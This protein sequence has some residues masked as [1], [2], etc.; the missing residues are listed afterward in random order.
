SRPRAERLTS[1][2][3]TVST[4]APAQA[5]TCQDSYGLPAYWFI[6]TGTEAIGWNTLEFQYWLPKAENSSGAV[7]PEMRASASR[8]PVTMP[9]I[10][11]RYSTCMITFHCGTPSASAAS[12]ICTGTSRSISSVVRITTGSTMKA[13][14]SAP[15][16]AENWPPVCITYSV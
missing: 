1:S 3:N 11:L 14:D 10:A 4:S 15:A 2:T 5:S 9:A 6:T 8:M 12:R 13:S 16:N 7:S